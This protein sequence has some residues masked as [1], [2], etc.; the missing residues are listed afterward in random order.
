M[1]YLVSWANHN[2][3]RKQGLYLT[4]TGVLKSFKQRMKRK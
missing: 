4:N 1:P 2:N 3:V